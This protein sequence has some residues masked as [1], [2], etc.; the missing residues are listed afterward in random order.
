[1]FFVHGQ[2]DELIDTSHSEKMMKLCSGHAEIIMPLKMTHNRLD[3][4]ADLVEPFRDFLLEQGIDLK[5]T[6]KQ[7]LDCF[8]FPQKFYEVP[9]LVKRGEK[10]QRAK[11]SF[12][13]WLVKKF[14]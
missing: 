3:F 5:G 8:E 2:E 13:S 11:M 1:M 10:V 4:S 6:D 14:G 7:D 9:E 12:W